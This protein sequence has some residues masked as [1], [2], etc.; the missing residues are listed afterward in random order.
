MDQS[1]SALSQCSDLGISLAYGR[2]ELKFRSCWLSRVWAHLH[3]FRLLVARE[4]ENTSCLSKSGSYFIMER[5]IWKSKYWYEITQ[6]A[7]ISLMF[8]AIINLI[9]RS[10]I[11]LPGKRAEFGCGREGGGEIE[12]ASHRRSNCICKPASNGLERQKA[13]C[14]SRTC[15]TNATKEM[16]SSPN[17]S[18]GDNHPR[19]FLLVHCFNVIVY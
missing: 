18:L 5:R 15:V 4:V 6:I 8:S 9:L 16:V 2:C 3:L 10:K 7:F 12:Q 17:N 13:C 1:V 11:I 19:C 14:S